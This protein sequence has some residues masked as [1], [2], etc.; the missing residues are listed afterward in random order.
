MARKEK[1]KKRKKGEDENVTSIQQRAFYHAAS[2]EKRIGAILAVQLQLTQSA[3]F[4]NKI[5]SIY[6]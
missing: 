5:P 1:A 3:C 4:S 2:V 6:A